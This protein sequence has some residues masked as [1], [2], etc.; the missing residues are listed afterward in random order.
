M[1]NNNINVVVDNVAF[2]IQKSGGISVVWYEIIKRLLDDSKYSVSFI[3]YG[4]AMQNMFRQMLA[5]PESD[6][7]IRPECLY[8]L[9]RYINPKL[10]IERPYIFHSSYYRTSRD[11][12]AINFTTVHD[13][14]YERS[15]NK[16]FRTLVH[17]WQQ[18]KAVMNSDV[19][20]CISENTK[21]EL[22]HFY[23]DVDE[24]K[25]YV[26]Y[27]GVSNDYC[28]I[29]QSDDDSLPFSKKSYCMFVGA[30]KAYKNFKLTVETIAN[31]KYNLVI[32]GKPLNEDEISYI[33]QYLGEDRY[34]CLSNV[35]NARLNELYNGAF[36]LL[37]LSAYEGFGIPC[38]EAQRAGCPVVAYNGTSIPEVMYDKDSLCDDLSVGTV[39]EKMHR[40]EDHEIYKKVIEEGLQFSKRFSWDNNYKQLTTLYDEALRKA[41]I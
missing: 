23:K 25:V 20:V 4:S 37:Y 27:N 36:V 39:I 35:S 21:R 3:E 1:T 29:E 11:A 5:I 24:S 30:R 38:L 14:N 8:R 13:F 22:L 31:T 40:L 33:E 32:V 6:I 9:E 17:I 41:S 19:V 16:D 26:V 18:K 34:C 7:T 15:G 10:G 12:N 2:T 28:K